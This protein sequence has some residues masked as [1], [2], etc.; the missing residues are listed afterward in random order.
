MLDGIAN[1]LTKRKAAKHL[2]PESKGRKTDVK[3]SRTF[4]DFS[5]LSND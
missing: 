5:E 2:L 4:M 1:A 3:R